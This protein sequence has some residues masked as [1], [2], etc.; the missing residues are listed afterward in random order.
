MTHRSP[1]TKFNVLLGNVNEG[2]RLV[3]LFYRQPRW[4]ELQSL[5]FGV[6]TGGTLFDAFIQRASEDVLDGCCEAMTKLL[7]AL[8]DAMNVCW[9]ARRANPSVIAQPLDQWRTVAP[10]ESPSGSQGFGE[11]LTQQLASISFDSLITSDRGGKRWLAG[12]VLDAR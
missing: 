3:R 9:S 12:R 10:T 8:V 6:R 11:D 2:V 7:V 1:A 4:S 5:V